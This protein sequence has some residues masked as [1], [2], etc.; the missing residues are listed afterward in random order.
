MDFPGHFMRR[1]KSVALT[2]PCVVGPYT[3][4][5]C[6]LRLLEHTFRTSP[7]AKDYLE[8]LDGTEDRFSTVNVPITSIAVSTAQNDS[9]V[10]ELNF[11][12]ER[13]IPFEG[14]GAISKW[15]LELPA[16][17]RQFDY[18]TITDVI[19]H[20]RYT[21]IEGGGKLKQA[22]TRALKDHV[23]SVEDL[24]REE[25]LFAIFDL[26]HDFPNEWYQVLRPVEDPAQRILV[27]N[28]LNERLPIFTKGTQKDKIKAIDVYLFTSPDLTSTPT[29]IRV[30]GATEEEFASFG[31]KPPYASK[32]NDIVMD[33]WQLKIPDTQTE[34]EKM[35]MVVRYILK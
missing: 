9:G 11:K 14:A 19:L 7:I 30:K 5:N 1:I 3:S 2:I 13:Y 12:D 28:N 25:G 20:L 34:I 32:D 33:T 26:K 8:R 29:L 16:D 10:F 22:A 35:W 15:R 21:S 6:T 23:A 18:E 31:V 24:S 27:L 4:V 17:F